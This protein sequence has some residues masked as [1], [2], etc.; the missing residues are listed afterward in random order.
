M[1]TSSLD[2][3]LNAVL[4]NQPKDWLKLTTHRLDIYNEGKAKIEFLEGLEALFNSASWDSASLENLP[5]AYDYIRLGHPLSCVLEWYVAK[6]NNISPNQVIA[7]SSNTMPILA[8]LRKNLLEGKAT[9]LVHSDALPS[10]FD[11]KIVREVYGYHFETQQVQNAQDISAFDGEV[12][13]ISEEDDLLDLPVNADIDY[14][15]RLLD[16]RGSIITIGDSDHTLS[17]SE[18]QHARRRESIAMTPQ[19]CYSLLQ[20][21]LGK[22]TENSEQLTAEKEDVIRIIHEVTGTQGSVVLGSSGLSVQYAIMMGLIHDVQ[23]LYPGK[24]I[25]FVIPPNCYGGTNDQARRVAKCL[26]HVEVM[27]LPVDGDHNMVQSVDLVLDQIADMNAVPLILVEIPT[28]PRVEVPDLEALK[29]SLE[30]TRKTRTRLQPSLLLLFWIKL[31]VRMF[32]F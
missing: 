19:N 6:M 25:K 24:E 4:D 10:Y 22:E 7:F 8:I 5:T 26:S 21:W 20:D 9:L 12:V 17:I 27:D 31:S 30:K 18:I 11:L 3:F 29:A 13:Y 16:N 1:A 32:N 14:H 15:I 23:N 2:T 28:N